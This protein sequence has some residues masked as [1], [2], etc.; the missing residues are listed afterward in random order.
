M[1]AAVAIP[2]SLETAQKI[3]AAAAKERSERIYNSQV[4]W[5][6]TMADSAARW[7]SGGQHRQI[8]ILA[9]A[10]HCHDSAIVRR[11]K[12]RGIDP[13]VSV[14]PVVETGE[15]ETA[16]L[17]AQPVTGLPD[18]VHVKQETF[19]HLDLD[20]RHGGQDRAVGRQEALVLQ[21]TFQ[22]GGGRPQ[23]YS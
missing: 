11:M 6:E 12:R 20:I 13:V 15:G 23:G 22:E 18:I 16:D 1:V 9:G 2:I 10:G 19:I 5:D 21:V 3:A 8:I 14:H 4:V 17:L 7:V